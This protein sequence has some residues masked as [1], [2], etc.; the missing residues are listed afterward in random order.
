MNYKTFKDI[1]EDIYFMEK[2]LAYIEKADSMVKGLISLNHLRES[3]MTDYLD[4]KLKSVIN[5]VK[6]SI[7]KD[8]EK[9]RHFLCLNKHLSFEDSKRWLEMN[10]D[11]KI[12]IS[13][14]CPD[15]DI[16]TP[17]K[18]DEH[19]DATKLIVPKECT[20]EGAFFLEK[21]KCSSCN[22]KYIIE[23]GV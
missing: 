7:K 23:N 18:R 14:S 16:Q 10:E 4:T 1:V 8:K 5:D 21:L 20:T 19:I 3:D 6:S 12:S 22:K 11:T 2:E 15:C 17:N 9:I 13:Y